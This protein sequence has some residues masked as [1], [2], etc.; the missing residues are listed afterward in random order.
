MSLQ[1][2]E[3][4]KKSTP[5]RTVLFWES[6]LLYQHISCHIRGSSGLLPA[7]FKL[8]WSNA[9]LWIQIRK[10]PHW[11]GRLVAYP[12]GQKWPTKTETNLKNIVFWSARSSLLGLKVS[13]SLRRPSWRPRNKY[14]AIFKEFSSAVKFAD[15]WSSKPWIQI[16]TRNGI[17]NRIDHNAGSGSAVNQCGS[18]TLITEK[19]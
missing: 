5:E 4:F 12:G 14:I 13:L 9:V 6:M 3:H 15:F 8:N 19:Q 17:R 18:T 10:D 1:V 16:W 2:G 11:F 7:I